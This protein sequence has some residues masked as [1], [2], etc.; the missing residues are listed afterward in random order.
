MAPSLLNVAVALT[1]L[2]SFASE[3]E[4]FR[5]NLQK[6]APLGTPLEWPGLRFQFTIKQSA[7]NVFGQ[8][9]I[10]MYANPVVSNN[11]A[12]VLYDVYATFTENNTLHN[13]TLVDS[14]AYIEDTPFSSGSGV[15]T[16]VTKCI[17]SESGALPAV[18]AIVAGINDAKNASTPSGA[19]A[20]AA[21]T[22]CYGGS[23]Y[24]T[25]V[26]KVEYTLCANG[27]AGFT[28]KSSDM[29]ISVL[30]L[31]SQIEVVP[32]T[33]NAAKCPRVAMPTAVTPIGHSLLTGEPISSKNARK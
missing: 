9:D 12:K 8:S 23:S 6:G 10:S 27:P 14:V 19:N 1:A 2:L 7:K 32:P 17:D 20:T 5:R 28:M 26:N 31:E 4:A 25:Q 24:K 29:D 18:N 33:L 30:Y 22:D 13:Y 21:P 15:V 3:T 11:N 16:P